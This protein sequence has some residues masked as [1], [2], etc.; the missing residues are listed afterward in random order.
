MQRPL[1]VALRRGNLLH[2]R[3]HQRL[4]AVALVLHVE[5]CNAVARRRIDDGEVELIVVRIELHEEFEH[6]VVYIVHT[7]IRT[8]NFIDDNDGLELLLQRLAQHIF[9]LRHRP[10]ECIHEE[11]DAVHH[12]QDAFHLAAE[13][14]VTWCIHDVDLDAVVEN[15]RVF[16]KN[17]NAALALNVARV[18]HAL[19]DLLVQAEHMT[20][21]QHR[22]DQR[23]LAVVNVCDDRNVAQLL[24]CT[25]IKINLPKVPVQK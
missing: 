16:R 20:L 9:R 13:I 19:A 18:H 6:F 3:L 1:G 14:R 21:T 5:L 24:I 17:R 22:V 2:N 10:L 12:V 25:H 7:L 15:R 8:V 4:E 23:R 11:Q